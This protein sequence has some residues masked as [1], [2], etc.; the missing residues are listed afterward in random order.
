MARTPR[1]QPAAG[2][3][4]RVF[5][6]AHET[7]RAIAEQELA[8]DLGTYRARIDA[9]VDELR[10]RGW[11]ED[12]PQY[13]LRPYGRLLAARGDLGRLVELATDP[14]RQERLLVAT[15]GDGAAIAELTAAQHLALEQPLCDLEAL[16]R[17]AVHKDHL[18]GR[19]RAVPVGLPALWVRLGQR[20]R[21]EALAR[22]LPHSRD[23]AQALAA[24][25]TALADAGR[26]D[27]AEATARGITDPAIRATALSGVAKVLA[28]ADRPR[29]EALLD[30]AERTVR[31]I[32]TSYVW[33]LVLGTVAEAMAEAR[34]W[35]R[36]ERAVAD[37]PPHYAAAGAGALRSVAQG[38]A[39]AGR[40]DH[41]ET[42]ARGIAASMVKA[43]ALALVGKAVAAVD[44][45]R[46]LALLEE[47]ERRAIHGGSIS[48]DDAEALGA[49]IRTLLEVDPGRRPAL[50]DAL[51]QLPRGVVPEGR[52]GATQMVVRVLAG[53]GL[54]DRAEA[55]AGTI[56][57]PGA[58]VMARGG[59]VEALA[60]AGR[61]DDAERTARTIETPLQLE[62][63]VAVGSSLAAVDRDRAQS[64]AENVEQ[65]ARRLS[66]AS[67]DWAR[68]AVAGAQAAIGQWDRAEAT[69]AAIPNPYV[70]TSALTDLAR[71]LAGAGHWDRA[72]RT[73]RALTDTSARA[74]ALGATA[75]A[76]V[77]ADR[78]RA[79]VL[80]DEAERL[81]GRIPDSDWR[82]QAAALRSVTLVLASVGELERAER[83]ALRTP[84]HSLT[85]LPHRAEALDAVLAALA[86]AR[87]WTQARRVALGLS[88]RTARIRALGSVAGACSRV[89][90][91]AALALTAEVERIAREVSRDGEQAVLLAAAAEALA[92][93]DPDHAGTLAAEAGRLATTIDDS[94]VRGLAGRAVAEAWAALGQWDEAEREV[95]GLADL[96]DRGEARLGLVEALRDAGELDRAE[97][98]ARAMEDPG[99][100]AQALAAVLKASAVVDQQ[101]AG[102]VAGDAERL[103]RAIDD[104][105]DQA[106]AYLAIAASLTPGPTLQGATPD[107]P[108]PPAPTASWGRC[109]PGRPGRRRWCRWP[110]CNPARW[111][112][113]A[114]RFVRSTPP[115]V[116]SGSAAGRG[117]VVAPA[118]PEGGVRAV[119]G[120]QLLVGAELGDPAVLDHRDPVGVMRGVEA[121]GDGDHGAAVQDRRQRAL[122]V[123]GG[124]RVEQRG[125]LVQDQG[126]GVGQDQA[127][128]GDLLGLGRA[129]GCGRR[130]RRPCPGR[131][132]G[133]RPS[134]GRRPPPGPSAAR[135]RRPRGGPGPGCRAG[136]RR[137]RAAPG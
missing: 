118:V 39:E 92:E 51:E 129:T 85:G 90:P 61:W 84:D 76:L 56:T 113:S 55:L 137:R 66:V 3:G 1:D 2:G 122:Q 116:R 64:L 110:G 99:R 79:L 103:A 135:R 65:L 40:W 89:D 111:R 8:G 80:A 29:A 13:P 86:S 72:E 102:R 9:W 100:R 104:P 38:L 128:Q 97:R 6:F 21:G 124:A 57:D 94:Y 70:R 10:E 130:P 91:P 87:E 109:W 117:R 105:S 31:G 26:S 77:R 32:R 43:E 37:I 120:D 49:V 7:L 59:L 123:A 22:A 35:Q 11:P 23:S 74:E 50:A 36:A 15:A 81:A 42:T 67:Q 27:R 119:G 30:E 45:D 127:G 126:V 106:K 62:V 134:R 108:L 112:R 107:D 125:R 20:D 19:N 78:D 132:A 115:K 96:D 33:P 4:E 16:G 41:A 44:R 133:P 75:E 73:A 14:G 48:P 47:A 63:L 101:R 34:F 17:L 98:V 52:A 82:E 131:R 46:G 121:V 5:L 83:T 24:V 53:N 88:D 68:H 69:A 60:G 114:G 71:S 95:S 93:V 58:Q 28:S 12:T 54:W 25:A 18:A 136:C